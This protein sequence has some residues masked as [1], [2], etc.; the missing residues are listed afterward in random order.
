CSEGSAV[1]SS[2]LIT[3]EIFMRQVNYCSIL[4][5]YES[6]SL[7]Q[8][9]E[10]TVYQ[11]HPDAGSKNHGQTRRDNPK[12]LPDGKKELPGK[13]KQPAFFARCIIYC[14]RCIVCWIWIE[15][16]FNPQWVHR[17]RHY[18]HFAVNPY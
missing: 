3:S 2:E 5:Y 16:F 7:K 6:V 17:W 8:S 9:R 4:T 11:Y 13:E 14:D 12:P 1:N 15:G 18:G 10:S